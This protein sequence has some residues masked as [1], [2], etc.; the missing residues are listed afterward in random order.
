MLKDFIDLVLNRKDVIS[1][2]YRSVPVKD[3]I[4]RIAHL[5][6]NLCIV[7]DRKI[8]LILADN[9][10]VKSSRSS[11]MSSLRTIDMAKGKT[12]SS[13]TALEE[14]LK[15]NASINSETAVILK[16]G[17]VLLGTVKK[18]GNQ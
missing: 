9:D 15:K 2:I 12:K 7:N 13:I 1:K 5:D 17:N 11:F 14:Y 10:P 6:K 8:W 4:K 18:S 3:L 16:D